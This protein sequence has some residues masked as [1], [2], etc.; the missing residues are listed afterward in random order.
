MIRGKEIYSMLTAEA[1]GKPIRTYKD[2]K[3]LRGFQQLSEG[4][5]VDVDGHAIR[6]AKPQIE[7]RDCSIRDLFENLVVNKSDGKP[8]GSAFVQQYFA[9]NSSQTLYEAGGMMGAVDSTMFMGITGQLLITQILKGYVAEEF[10]ATGMVPTYPSMLESEKW[11]GVA[12]PKDP[13]KNIL[14]VPE[15]DSFKTVG[16]GEEYV[17]TPLTVKEGLI[18]PV[19]KEAIFFDRTGLVIDRAGK[20]GYLLGLSKEKEILGCMIGGNT[21]V[22]RYTEKRAYDTAPIALDVFQYAGATGSTYTTSAG[23]TSS[24]YQLAYTYSTRPYPYSNDIPNNPLVD[25]KAVRLAEAYFSKTVDPNTG[26]PIVVGKPFVFATEVRKMDLAQILKAQNILK[27]SQAGVTSAGSILTGS[28]NPLEALGNVEFKT[29]RQLRSQMV[30]QLFAGTD[31]GAVVDAIWF[32]GDPSRAF[33]YVE[34]WPLTVTQAPTNSEA[35]FSQD[36]AVRFKAS[37]RG[38]VACAEPR[39]W[40]RSNFITEDS[41][42]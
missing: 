26:E 18:I 37:R 16:F 33:A 14:R 1:Q 12:L 35:E 11:P 2:M 8:V 27:I 15:G 40:S 6:D 34:N 4:C 17:Q 25:Y 24:T 30:T 32:Y 31:S 5:G 9:P 39:C 21:D 36:I 10:I 7:L 3:S 23:S 13:G 38:R 22:V 29:S 41:A 19:T 42:Y 28:P 20:V